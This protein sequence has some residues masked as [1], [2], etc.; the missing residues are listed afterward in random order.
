M[1]ETA[2]YEAVVMVEGVSGVVGVHLALVVAPAMV[3]FFVAEVVG[4]GHCVVE[5]RLP[6]YIVVLRR[7]H[8]LRRWRLR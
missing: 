6:V 5:G 1:H 8:I 2:D 3:A 4:H 7:R